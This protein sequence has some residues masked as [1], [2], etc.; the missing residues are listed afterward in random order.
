MTPIRDD[1]PAWFGSLAITVIALASL[2][3]AG[4][5]RL[6]TD[7]ALLTVGAL[8]GRRL[9]H[10]RSGRSHPHETDDPRPPAGPD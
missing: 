6:A 7:L 1:R 9:A 3:D 2:V 8:L 5:P 10:A 4:R